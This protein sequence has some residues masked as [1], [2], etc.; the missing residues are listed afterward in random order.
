MTKPDKRYDEGFAAGREHF[1]RGD[2]ACFSDAEEWVGYALDLDDD[3]NAE[4]AKGYLAGWKRGRSHEQ[5]VSDHLAHEE[6]MRKL[7]RK[8]AAS[9]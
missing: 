1:E 8:N 4:F 7:R 5:L 3:D 6:L 2:H 9:R